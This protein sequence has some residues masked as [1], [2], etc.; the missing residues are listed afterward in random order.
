MTPPATAAARSLPRSSPAARRVAAS[1]SGAVRRAVAVR[2]PRRVSGPTARVALAGGAVALPAPGVG[3]RARS[4]TAPGIALRTIH[5]LDGVSRSALLERLIRVRI[6]IGV[7]A[8]SL[9]GIVAMQLVVLKLNNQIGRTLAREVVLQRENAQLGIEASETSSGSLVEPQAAAA[10]MTFAAPGSLHFLRAHRGQLAHAAAALSSPI[11]PVSAPEASAEAS[12]SPS[13]ATSA[14]AASPPG[15]ASAEAAS[16]P[17]EA[18]GAAASSSEA[19][20]VSTPEG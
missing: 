4:Q 9:I 12:T 13:A 7:L 10:G 18:S 3:R 11:Q 20:T 17:G 2:H 1:S 5:A 16:P 19:T 6:W 8:F 14:E 15:E